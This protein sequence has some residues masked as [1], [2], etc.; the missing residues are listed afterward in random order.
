[1][2]VSFSSIR[3]QKLCNSEK[4]MRAKFGVRMADKLAQRLSELRAV[5]ILDDLSRLPSA[6]CHELSHDRAGQLAVDLIHP[7]RLIFEP[8]HN[9]IPTKPDGG[10][11]WTKVTRVTVLE[12]V[13]YH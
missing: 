7:K 3:L 8:D 4:E 1:M 10:L 11:N 13:D 9:P 12:I 5:D 6:R 2:V